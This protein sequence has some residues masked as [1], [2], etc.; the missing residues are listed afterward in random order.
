MYVFICNTKN[1]LH[2]LITQTIK[3]FRSRSKGLSMHIFLR[4]LQLE[5]ATIVYLYL[6]FHKPDASESYTKKDVFLQ[7]DFFATYNFCV[8]FVFVFE[9]NVFIFRATW[10]TSYQTNFRIW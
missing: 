5:T 4:S 9:K 10:H 1:K 3:V 6:H 7:F 2:Y 8:L